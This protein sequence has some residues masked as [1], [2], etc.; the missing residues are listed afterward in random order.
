MATKTDKKIRKIKIDDETTSVPFMVYFKGFFL[1]AVVV[2][3]MILISYAARNQST[4]KSQDSLSERLP[5]SEELAQTF[6]KDSIQKKIE[7]EIRTNEVYK[8]TVDEVQKQSNVVLGEASKAASTVIEESKEIVTD[9]IYEYTYGKIVEGMVN[10]LPDR[11]KE[12]LLQRMC[13]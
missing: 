9:Q 1:V 11:Q 6:S 8:Q 10:A 4:K 7:D 2:T 13:K 3:G 12:L 5:S